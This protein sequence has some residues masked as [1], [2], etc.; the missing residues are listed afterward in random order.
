[1]QMDKAVVLDRVLD[2]NT[3][4]IVMLVSPYWAGYPTV[5]PDIRYNA[6]K[7]GRDHPLILCL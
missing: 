4:L 1:M 5:L 2:F 6:K 3:L 7:I